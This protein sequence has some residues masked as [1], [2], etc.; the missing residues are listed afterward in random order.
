MVF[1]VT[2]LLACGFGVQLLRNSDVARISDAQRQ[3]EQA[4]AQLQSHYAS[5]REDF[6][7]RNLQG[8]STETD[9][10][11]VTSILYERNGFV[12]LRI[13]HLSGFWT[14]ARYSGGGAGNDPD[15]RAAR[16]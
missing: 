6:K 15:G 12:G 3:L 16:G 11:L 13:S 4:T 9:N 2:I 10:R 8:P 5:L 14:K 1:L 7:Q